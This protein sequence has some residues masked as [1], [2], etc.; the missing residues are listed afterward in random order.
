MQYL[1]IF[2]MTQSETTFLTAR[3]KAIC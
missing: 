3:E 2:S 1:F